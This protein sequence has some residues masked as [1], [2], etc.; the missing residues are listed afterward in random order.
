MFSYGRLGDGC[1]S[2][3]AG[4]GGGG[5]TRVGSAS[6]TS[7]P[8]R[9]AGREVTGVVVYDETRTRLFLDPVP[10]RDITLCVCREEGAGEG[11]GECNCEDGC[12]APLSC[13]KAPASFWARAMARSFSSISFAIVDAS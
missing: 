7:S 13:G 6:C 8:V 2:A 3:C 12:E 4:V 11:E 1:L 9:D 10:V 5:G